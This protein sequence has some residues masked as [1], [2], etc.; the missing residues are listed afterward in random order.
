VQTEERFT[1]RFQGTVWTLYKINAAAVIAAGQLKQGSLRV[2][3][4]AYG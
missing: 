3:V 2:K 4:F 1:P